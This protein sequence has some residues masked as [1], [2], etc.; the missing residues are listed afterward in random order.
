MMSFDSGELAPRFRSA[1]TS[2]E[3]LHVPRRASTVSLT[4][5]SKARGARV[6]VVDESSGTVL[7]DAGEESLV[8]G[9]PV[10]DE[11]GNPRKMKVVVTARDGVSVETYEVSVVQKHGV[12][13]GRRLLQ[14]SYD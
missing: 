1:H 8:S 6:S 7:G 11:H 10:H 12:G 13:S 9:I 5:M 4:W 3:L 2:Y 14:R